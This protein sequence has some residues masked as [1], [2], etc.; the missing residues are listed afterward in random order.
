MWYGMSCSIQGVSYYYM[1]NTISHRKSIH[2]MAFSVFLLPQVS[3]W[4]HRMPCI[5]RS[6]TSLCGQIKHA[7]ARGLMP[8]WYLP[9]NFSEHVQQ[10]NIV[11]AVNLTCQTCFTCM[12]YL[13]G[14][15]LD[16][17]LQNLAV[18][19]AVYQSF[20]AILGSYVQPGFGKMVSHHVN[21][22][23]RCFHTWQ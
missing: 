14:T 16:I 12:I 10:D 22:S 20:S 7:C 15:I 8:E 6:Q 13:S 3:S 9:C 19:T 18:Y 2:G 11:Y 23:K 4:M 5:G 17:S 21:A 1:V